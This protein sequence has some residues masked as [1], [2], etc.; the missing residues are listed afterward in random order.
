MNQ[1]GR[2]AL[3]TVLA[4][5]LLTVGDNPFFAADNDLKEQFLKEAPVAW[6]EYASFLKTIQGK[7]I[8]KATFTKDQRVTGGFLE[9]LQN[10]DCKLIVA[11]DD[12]EKSTKGYLIG[13]NPDYCFKLTRLNPTDKWLFSSAHPSQNLQNEKSPLWE[14]PELF[15]T[16][17]TKALLTLERVDL[18]DLVK[19]K[20][21]QIKSIKPV[22]YEGDPCVELT[23]NSRHEYPAKEGSEPYY[24]EQSGTLVLD[25]QKSWLLRK[26][27]LIC[28]YINVQGMA[29]DKEIKIRPG[30]E[31]R[32]PIPVESNSKTKSVHSNRLFDYTSEKSLPPDSR[33]RLPAYGFPEMGETQSPTRWYLWFTLA[34]LCFLLGGWLYSR[35]NKKKL[36]VNASS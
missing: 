32:F 25:P 24:P 16:L 31:P 27:N 12:H 18:R 30:P 22:V 11:Q 33:F 23:F 1:V 21:F 26:A 19:K 2:Y 20:E 28:D 9:I 35:W 3:A 14:E 17:Q 7:T 10:K 36:Q 34:G 29:F 13:C 15:I 6:N 8:S 4:L 5:L